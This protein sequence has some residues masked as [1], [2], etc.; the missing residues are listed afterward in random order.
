MRWLLAFA[1]GLI[2]LA[3]ALTLLLVFVGE[4]LQRAGCCT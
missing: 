1:W 2:A 4:P 3:I